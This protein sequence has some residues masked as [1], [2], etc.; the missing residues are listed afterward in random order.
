MF[1][2]YMFVLPPPSIGP[3]LLR[4]IPSVIGVV[5]VRDRGRPDPCDHLVAHLLSLAGCIDG[6]AGVIDETEDNLPVA[7]FK[8]GDMVSVATGPFEGMRGLLRADRGGERV[9]VLLELL[10][11]DREV[12]L[13]REWVASH[14][15]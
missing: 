15:Q 2:G 8:V 14:A 10:G 12:E 5:G 3:A 13:S 9:T 7:R 11:G 6:M 4:Q 1:P